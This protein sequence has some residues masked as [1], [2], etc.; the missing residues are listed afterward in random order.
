MRKELRE[1]A[2]DREERGNKTEQTGGDA[3]SHAEAFFGNEQRD[4]GPDRGSVH[5]I[6]DAYQEQQ[7]QSE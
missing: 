6:S 7:R 4:G 2:T 3:V 5:R 1:K